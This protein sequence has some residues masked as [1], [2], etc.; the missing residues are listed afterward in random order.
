[1]DI[2][3]REAVLEKKERVG[4]LEIDTIIGKNH[5]GA[6]VTINYRATGY[7][8]IRKLSGKEAAPLAE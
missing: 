2:S 1:M 4:N 8:W 5:K 6:A 3:Q 7:L